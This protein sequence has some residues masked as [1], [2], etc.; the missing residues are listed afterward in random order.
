LNIHRAAQKLNVMVRR[1]RQFS[2]SGASQ[3]LTNF[4]SLMQK[5]P[6]PVPAS[7][8]LPASKSKETPGMGKVWLK[9]LPQ[10]V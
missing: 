9:C 8:F 4:S 2:E 10:I 7:I 5:S 3:Q 6:P 1:G